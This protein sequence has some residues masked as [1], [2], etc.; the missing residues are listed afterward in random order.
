[1]TKT[2]YTPQFPQ[3]PNG[4]QGWTISVYRGHED[5]QP[6]VGSHQ[7]WWVSDHGPDGA[8]EKA[9]Q[10][11]AFQK[12]YDS[13]RRKQDVSHYVAVPISISSIPSTV[14]AFDEENYED[15]EVCAMKTHLQEAACVY[16]G[17][18]KDWAHG[19]VIALEV[20]ASKKKAHK[21]KKSIRELPEVSEAGMKVLKAFEQRPDDFFTMQRLKTHEIQKR[22]LIRLSTLY[23]VIE[24]LVRQDLLAD[25]VTRDG[26]E[27]F[28]TEDGD[29]V[30]KDHNSQP[31]ASKAQNDGDDHV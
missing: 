28:R 23:R 19:D 9:Y 4:I 11:L 13:E 14:P 15:C 27:F 2:P 8:R 16:C 21:P 20:Q 10:H 3:D 30:L 5:N 24:K 1:M 29:K 6:L 12:D 25:N 7:V 31:V 26:Q 17:V 22:T 18:T